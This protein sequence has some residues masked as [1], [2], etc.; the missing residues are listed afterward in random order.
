MKSYPIDILRTRKYSDDEIRILHA[1]AFADPHD[2]GYIV[3]FECRDGKYGSRRVTGKDVFCMRKLV[4]FVKFLP[5]L[6]F[7]STLG[8]GGRLMLPYKSV[9][10]CPY[11][12]FVKEYHWLYDTE[13]W[14]PA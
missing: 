8:W 13:T 7:T 3:R 2:W 10:Q 6:E 12:E 9:L 11:G 1:W 5:M 4:T 14:E